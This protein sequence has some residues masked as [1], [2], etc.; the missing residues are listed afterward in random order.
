MTPVTFWPITYRVKIGVHLPLLIFI[1]SIS[2]VLLYF[3]ALVLNSLFTVLKYEQNNVNQFYFQSY[4]SNVNICGWN[5]LGMP[6]NKIVLQN[7]QINE[8]KWYRIAKT[9]CKSNHYTSPTSHLNEIVQEKCDFNIS[10]GTVFWV[11][12]PGTNSVVLLYLMRATMTCTWSS[13]MSVYQPWS[14]S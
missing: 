14:N 5:L 6:K 9:E 13:I 3:L 1:H 10:N 12:W 7:I 2:T 11:L 4:K 8:H